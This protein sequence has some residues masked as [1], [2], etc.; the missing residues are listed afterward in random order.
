MIYILGALMKQN[1]IQEFAE[2]Y[3]E[4]QLLRIL[5]E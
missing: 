3:V 2:E 4:N 5:K 1:I